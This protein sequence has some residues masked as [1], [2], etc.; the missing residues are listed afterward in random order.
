M[1][2]DQR[3]HR[4]REERQDIKAELDQLDNKG[5]WAL[6]VVQ[7]PKGQWELLVLRVLLVCLAQMAHQDL[8]E[9]PDSLG[10]KVKGE[11]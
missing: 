5:L 3:D 9:A 7:V 1:L 6:T 8:R 4:D 10:S 2:G 11:M